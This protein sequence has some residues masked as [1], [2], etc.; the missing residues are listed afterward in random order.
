[1]AVRPQ[2]KLI[3]LINI[4]LLYFG[5]SDVPLLKMIINA[6]MFCFYVSFRGTF[7][8]HD[9]CFHM[10]SLKK[11]MGG[12]KRQPPA[13]AMSFSHHTVSFSGHHLSIRHTEQMLGPWLLFFFF[14]N[15]YSNLLQKNALEMHTGLLHSSHHLGESWAIQ[16]NEQTITWVS[17]QKLRICRNCEF[18]DIVNMRKLW[19][20]KIWYK[21]R[22]GK[23]GVRR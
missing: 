13:S 15:S 22:M 7:L 8:F 19:L 23:T 5:V 9:I 4:P 12:G 11:E 17:P 10:I 3:N 6:G 1:M 14:R 18:A 20:R 2:K 21:F 16:T